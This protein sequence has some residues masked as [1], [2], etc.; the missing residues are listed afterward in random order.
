MLEC[1]GGT[2]VTLKNPE[3][4]EA[5]GFD[6][7]PIDSKMSKD[8]EKGNYMMLLIEMHEARGLDQI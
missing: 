4:R 7:A 1:Q 8:L 3:E 2:W 6:P 5:G